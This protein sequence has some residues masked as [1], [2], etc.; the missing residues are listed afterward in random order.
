M[1]PDQSAHGLLRTPVSPLRYENASTDPGDVAMKLAQWVPRGS[2]FLDIGCGTGSVTE[3]IMKARGATAIAIEPDQERARRAAE[4]GI[5]VRVE[6]LSSD[7]V[8]AHGPFP[9]I[10]VADVLEHLQSPTRLL[11]Q[12]RPALAPGGV[13]LL[14]VPNVAH[15]FIRLDLL[16]GK[17]DY[18]ESGIMDATHLRW[19]T[20]DSLTALLDHSGY[21]VTDIDATVN[22]SLPDYRRRVPWRWL[23]SR[24]RRGL[25]GLLVTLRPA[26][27]GCQI[28]V[29]AAR[30]D[31]ATQD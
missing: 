26:L 2:R 6:E 11:E 28:V 12:I 3:A 20:R 13:L 16:T 14:S 8:R 10:V 18:Q 27:F 5:D 1:S 25:I 31:Q 23:P 22:A 9:V 19:F 17:F 7:L 30:I 21:R 29:R 24:V 4:R 15:W